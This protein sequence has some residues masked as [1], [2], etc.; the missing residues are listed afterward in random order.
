MGCPAKKVMKW[1][2]LLFLVIFFLSILVSLFDHSPFKSVH[3]HYGTSASFSLPLDA[4]Y[5]DPGYTWSLAIFFFPMWN[6][7]CTTSLFF[8][9]LHD[10]LIYGSV[11]YQLG[12]LLAFGRRQLSRAQ[13]GFLNFSASIDDFFY[14]RCVLQ[15]LSSG[16]LRP[17]R[18]SASNYDLQS[19]VKTQEFLGIWLPTAYNG[20]V[21]TFFHLS[22]DYRNYVRLLLN[23]LRYSLVRSS[24]FLISPF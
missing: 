22:F 11:I 12:L 6:D 2:I 9:F 16:R 14:E 5:R 17:A 4:S 19:V 24:T 7:D 18:G 10:I 1:C 20:T 21:A 13:C 8:F 15:H 23:L 3:D